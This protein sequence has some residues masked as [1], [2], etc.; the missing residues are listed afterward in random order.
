MGEKPF[1]PRDLAVRA[2]ELI[3]NVMSP[4]T[5]EEVRHVDEALRNVTPSA[6]TMKIGDHHGQ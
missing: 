3:Q 1:Q 4:V 5:R 6:K 2:L